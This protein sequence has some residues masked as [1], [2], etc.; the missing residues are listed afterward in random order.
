MSFKSQRRHHLGLL[1]LMALVW[2]ATALPAMADPF[3]QQQETPQPSVTEAFLKQPDII[4]PLVVPMLGAFA[5]ILALGVFL[6]WVFS[7]LP[8]R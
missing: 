8:S 3:L 5:A 6:A 7:R 1:L 4:A 2:L